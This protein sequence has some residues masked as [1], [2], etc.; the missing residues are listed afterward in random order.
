MATESLPFFFFLFVTSACRRAEVPA[1]VSRGGSS[2]LAPNSIQITVHGNAKHSQ[3]TKF[4]PLMIE[5]LLCVK[6]ICF[7][8]IKQPCR[9]V[10]CK[11][12]LTSCFFTPC[13]TGSGRILSPWG[14]PDFLRVNSVRNV[15]ATH[16]GKTVPRNVRLH[17]HVRT[18]A[19]I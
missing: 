2:T 10:R 5:L 8:E 7:R 1:I 18:H 17:V 15:S 14:F 16:L 19:Q 9:W 11:V 4:A 6:S 12:L 13:N 3:T